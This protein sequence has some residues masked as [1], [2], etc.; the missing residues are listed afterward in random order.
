MTTTA[1]FVGP[2]NERM[3][4]FFETNR[5]FLRHPFK[6]DGIYGP[7]DTV[8]VDPVVRVER[9]ATMPA[10]RFVSAGAYT[11]CISREMPPGVRLG[12]YCS[13]A[14]NVQVLEPDTPDNWVTTRAYPFGAGPEVEDGPD[15]ARPSRGGWPVLGDDVW[16]GQDVMIR[17]GV[18][19]GTGAIV[20]AGAVVTENVAPYTIVG[21]VN[22]RPIRLR[23]PEPLVERMLKVQWWRYNYADFGDLPM[24][25]PDAFL[26]G[27][28]AMIAAGEIAP[29]E[30]GVL[31]LADALRDWMA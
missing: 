22:A 13:V 14:K 17:R 21:G 23:F 4:A 15:G 27:L 7:G 9:Y 5:I 29:F 19:I 28:E 10:R 12:R 30:P 1:P 20:A 8:T 24:E 3:A 26:D 11:Y 18:T 25:H 2:F 16:I 31:V 6:V